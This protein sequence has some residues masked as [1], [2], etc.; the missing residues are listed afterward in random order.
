[1]R[2]FIA[3]L[4]LGITLLAAGANSASAG[5]PCGP[6]V[7]TGGPYYVRS[8]YTGPYVYSYPAVAYTTPVY[9][10]SAYPYTSYYTAPVVNSYY[11]RVT[12]YYSG[13]S[14]VTYSSSYFGA[15]PVGGYISTGYPILYVR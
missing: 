10:S 9:T 11:P 14:P 1:M 4:A 13:Y 12:T 7:Y 8:Y 2:K 15:Y 6:V 5:W 3:V